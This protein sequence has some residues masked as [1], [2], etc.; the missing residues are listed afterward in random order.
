[1]AAP[2]SIA[3]A[4]P[5]DWSDAL[6]LVFRHLPTKDRQARAANALTLIERGELDPAGL[7][8][9]CGK[10]GL[11]GAVVCTTAAGAS[12]LI[13]PPQVVPGTSQAAAIEDALV[14]QA[15]EWLR[16]RGAR[17]AQAL[18]HPD[19]ASLA[20]SLERNGFDHIT[21]LW[22]LRNGLE[23]TA[24]LP[25]FDRLEFLPY[26]AEPDR[27]EQTLLR[28][29]EESRDCPEVTG[30]RTI[31]EIIAGHRAQGS[32]TPGHWWLAKGGGQPVGVLLLAEMAEWNGWDLSYLGIVPEARQGGFGR[33]LVAKAIVEA[34]MAEI[35][36]L[37]LSVD[38]RNLPAWKLYRSMGFEPYDQREVFLAI[39]RR[40]N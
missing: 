10:S 38:G 22:Y 23:W 37:T 29:Y 17:L 21:R 6:H 12:G 19:E 36:Q 15:S 34:R 14:R 33:E 20:A 26:A 8:A 31:E 27:F 2:Y 13:W 5:E 25:R 24:A 30:V 16:Q 35:A 3:P 18:L 1:M 4:Q 9:A 28:T 39:W 32:G 7:L 40:A 11:V